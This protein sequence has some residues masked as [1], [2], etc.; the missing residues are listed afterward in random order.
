[1]PVYSIGP[2]FQNPFVYKYTQVWQLARSGMI[3]GC[4]FTDTVLP[5]TRWHYHRVAAFPLNLARK[6]S[7][8]GPFIICSASK[9]LA[10]E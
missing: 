1:M 8:Q 9:A 2:C 5:L 4:A 10:I 3:N 7:A 6:V